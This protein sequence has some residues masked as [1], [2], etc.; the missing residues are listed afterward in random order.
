MSLSHHS[1]FPLRFR[2]CWSTCCTQTGEVVASG[3]T[4]DLNNEIHWYHKDGTM[5]QK[6]PHPRAC[7]HWDVSVCEIKVTGTVYILISC[8]KCNVITAQNESNHEEHIAYKHPSVH[9]GRMCLGGVEELC[10]I[11]V[12]KV[13]V[14]DTSNKEF[15]V[16]MELDIGNE[17]HHLCYYELPK[18]GGVVATVCSWAF[19]LEAFSIE[20]GQRLFKLGGKDE[21]GEKLEVAGDTWNPQALQCDGSTHRLYLADQ[22]HPRILMLDANTGSVLQILT[23]P[24]LGLPQHLTWC[25]KQAHHTQTQLIVQHKKDYKL[26]ISYFNVN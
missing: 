16:K 5:R 20:T 26:G 3:T 17:V 11:N 8:F 9:P 19:M 21:S 7:E 13:T 22:A 4:K 14:F 1:A 2:S 18:V 12:E 25:P 24:Q 15:R 23:S 6:I 10:A